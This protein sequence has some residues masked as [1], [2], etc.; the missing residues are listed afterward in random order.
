MVINYA[1]L[2][3]D[4]LEY[5]GLNYVNIISMAYIQFDIPAGRVSTTFT[6][7]TPGTAFTSSKPEVT[8]SNG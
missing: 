4:V 6:G 8:F 3:K 2:S 1:Y 7:S 5:L